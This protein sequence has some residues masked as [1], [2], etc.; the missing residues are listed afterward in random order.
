[1]DRYALPD[2]FDRAVDDWDSM[3]APFNISARTPNQFRESRL[4]NRTIR[5]GDPEIYT[6]YGLT[7][8]QSAEIVHFDPFPEN[9]RIL[10]F[11]YQSKH[12]PINSDQDKILYPH[13]YME[14]LIDLIL[15]LANRDYE[16]KDSAKVQQL[17]I[18]SFRAHNAQ[19][20]NPGTTDGGPILRPANLVR[21]SMRDAYGLP[22]TSVDW[23]DAW[24]TG[25]HLGL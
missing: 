10:Q 12:P 7:D 21:S 24:D 1:M 2:D 17:I 16:D 20:S 18:D 13:S 5:L 14:A 4:T 15:Q 19:Q 6:K 11:A 3:F 22:A 9:A 25:A 8:N 23:G